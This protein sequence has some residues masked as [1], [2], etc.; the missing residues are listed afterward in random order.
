MN[1]Y[2]GTMFRVVAKHG[3]FVSDTS[4]DS[5]V[6]VWTTASPDAAVRGNACAAAVELLQ[7]VEA[8]NRDR[9]ERRLPTRVGLESGE[10]M[11]GNVGAE[12]RFEYRAIG[13]IV[14]TAS[15]IQG[16][17]AQLGTRLLVSADTL[18]GVAGIPG[19]DLGRF[20]LRGK[21]AAVRVYEPL[22][23][24]PP[25]WDSARLAAEFAAALGD[26]TEQ[27]WHAAADGFGA[28][29]QRYPGDGPSAYFLDLCRGYGRAP[30][31]RWD[32]VV[33]IATK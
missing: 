20:R 4:G 21:T 33:T 17:N 32:G 6:A 30:P 10:L 3:G 9:G 7:A 12:Q 28:L 5:M 16:L 24:L 23:M 11:L 25:Q 26:F 1:D 14:N 31:V 8:F 27:R 18:A 2:F 22:A 19:R 15:R 13:D 29:L